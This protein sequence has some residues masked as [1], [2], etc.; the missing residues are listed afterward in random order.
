M[1]LPFLCDKNGLV[2]PHQWVSNTKYD[3]NN[4]NTCIMNSNRLIGNKY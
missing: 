4:C 3:N 2:F 1:Y